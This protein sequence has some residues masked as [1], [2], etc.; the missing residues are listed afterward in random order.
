MLSFAT[1]LGAHIVQALLIATVALWLLI[2]VFWILI[3]RHG[4]ALQQGAAGLWNVATRSRAAEQLRRVPYLAGTA[5]NLARFVRYI[6]LHAVLSLAVAVAG[7]AA[8]VEIAEEIG[9]D[10]G[11]AGFDHA[12]AQ[13]FHDRLS[14]GILRFFATVTHLGDFA[15]MVG[16]VTL[17]TIVLCLRREWRLAAA[18]A[19]ATSLGGGLNVIL[20]SLFERS[21][22]LHEH[23]FAQATGWSFPSGHASGSMIVYGL[24]G[25]LLVRRLPRTWHIPIALATATLIVVI[26]SSRVI[27]QVHYFSDVLAGYASAGAWLAMWVAGLEAARGRAEPRGHLSRVTSS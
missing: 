12:L 3:H 21:R 9:L 22:P 18:W 26:G 11:L 5:S 4:A 7:F 25:Y 17:V 6:G 13:S 24:L 10:E 14:A 27:L 8:F 23:G 19:I 2:S 20:K 1:Y 16:L 15:F